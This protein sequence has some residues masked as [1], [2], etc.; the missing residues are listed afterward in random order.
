MTIAVKT[1]DEIRYGI[2]DQVTGAETWGT[3]RSDN[4]YT[5]MDVE[6]TSFL[7]DARMRDVNRSKNDSRVKETGAIIVDS[8]G[9]MP[10]IPLKG[11]L[12]K[13]DLDM[14]LYGVFQ[15]VTEAGA[16]TFAKVF[17]FPSTVGTL[18]PDF[19]ADAGFFA[20][21]VKQLP[22]KTAS[23]RLIDAICSELVLRWAPEGDDSVGKF[24]A[25]MIGRGPLDMAADLSA[26]TFSRNPQADV[27]LFYF[28]DLMAFSGDGNSLDP[29]GLEIRI[30]NNAKPSKAPDKSDLGKFKTYVLGHPHYGIEV[31]AKILYDANSYALLQDVQTL[32]PVP[33]V[34]TWGTSGQDGYLN[35]ALQMSPDPVSIDVDED[36]NSI[37]FKLIGMQEGA[38]KPAT[39]T[40]ENSI[41]RNWPA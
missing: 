40:L 15:N 26:T 16:G 3:A 23:H 28:Q 8:K 14:F 2:A 19:T 9:A 11:L 24:D 30:F 37:A 21:I 36:E 31:N 25:N 32:N 39:V 5:L 20:T 27:D 29:L 17:T 18:Q 22:T 6:P 34:I 38:T 4:T 13:D 1:K 41:D 7:S 33:W 12:K 35:F 10:S